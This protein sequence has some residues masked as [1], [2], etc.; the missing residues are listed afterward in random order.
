MVFLSQNSWLTGVVAGGVLIIV[1]AIAFVATSRWGWKAWP[2]LLLGTLLVPTLL[3]AAVVA[4]IIY[5]DQTIGLAGGFV[6]HANWLIL[7]VFGP[8]IVG[9]AL[10]LARRRYKAKGS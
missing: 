3:Y 6:V 9:S 10:G 7:I 4:T 1:G 2:I 8:A 5:I